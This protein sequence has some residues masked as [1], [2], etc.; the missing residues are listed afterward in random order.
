MATYLQRDWKYCYEVVG[1]LRLNRTRP[2]ESFSMTLFHQKYRS[3]TQPSYSQSDALST[4]IQIEQTI[5]IYSDVSQQR[6]RSNTRPSKIFS[7]TLFHQRYRSN[8]L[9]SYQIF[10]VTLSQQRYGGKNIGV[11]NENTNSET[12]LIQEDR[13]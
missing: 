7:L 6:Y 12:V 13:S 5:F 3:N 8:A 11:T 9:P 4:K 2:S 1:A 10:S